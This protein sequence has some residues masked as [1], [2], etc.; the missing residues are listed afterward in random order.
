MTE[1]VL[2]FAI[3]YL[4]HLFISLGFVLLGAATGKTKNNGNAEHPT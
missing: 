1:I 4:I 3:D 2:P